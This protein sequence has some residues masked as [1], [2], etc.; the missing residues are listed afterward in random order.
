[1]ELVNE[2]IAYGW[3]YLSW[4]FFILIHITGGSV[5]YETKGFRGYIK[6]YRK[7]N[8]ERKMQNNEK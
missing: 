5:S 6:E 1:L 4:G 7:L 8:R 2:I 3:F